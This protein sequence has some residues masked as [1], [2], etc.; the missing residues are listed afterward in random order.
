MISRMSVRTH[1]QTETLTKQDSM[2]M[3]KN[4]IKLGISLV[5]YLRNLF[6][7]NAYEEVHIQELKL[8]KLLPINREAHMIINWLEK[9]VFDAIEKEYLRILILDINDIYDNSIECYKFSF[10]YNSF[11]GGKIGITLETS[12]NNPSNVSTDNI[13]EEKRKNFNIDRLKDIKDRL[14]N[15]NKKKKETSLCFKKD[16]KQKTYELLRSLVLLTQTLNPLP[17]R[18]YLSMKLLYYDEIVPYNYQ[19][20]Y[21]RNPDSKDL[22]KFVNIPNEEH[23]GKV[24]TGHHYLS[25]IVNST[26]NNHDEQASSYN[27]TDVHNQ[28]TSNS[29]THY[30]K[31]V[32]GDYYQYDNSES[33]YHSK[34]KN[35]HGQN[36]NKDFYLHTDRNNE[37]PYGYHGVNHNGDHNKYVEYDEENCYKP[38]HFDESRYTYLNKRLSKKRHRKQNKNQY[39]IIDDEEYDDQEEVKMSNC[40]ISEGVYGRSGNNR[41]VDN[42]NAAQENH[43]ED[44]S[45]DY[46]YYDEYDDES[47]NDYNNEEEYSSFSNEQVQKGTKR[48]LKLIGRKKRKT[49]LAP[50]FSAN[51]SYDNMSPSRA[52][53]VECSNDQDYSSNSENNEYY[54]K[55]GKM[56]VHTHRYDD[57]KHDCVQVEKREIEQIKRKKNKYWAANKKVYDN[58]YYSSNPY[59]SN[60]EKIAT[61]LYGTSYGKKLPY[62][63]SR[64]EVTNE[65]N[66]TYD[67]RKKS[68]E[69]TNRLNKSHKLDL[70]NPFLDKDIEKKWIKNKYENKKNCAKTHKNKFLMKIKNKKKEKLVCKNLKNKKTFQKT[71]MLKY[72]KKNM[73]HSIRIYITRYKIL[74]KTKI[75]QKFPNVTNCD[76][77]T[78]LHKL[79]KDNIIRKNGC[80]SYTFV[81]DKGCKKKNLQK[82]Y[83]PQVDYYQTQQQVELQNQGEKC[84]GKTVESRDDDYTDFQNGRH[85]DVR[86]ESGESNSHLDKKSNSDLDQ[87]GKSDICKERKSDI[88]KERKSDIGKERK[89]DRANEPAKDAR[90]DPPTTHHPAEHVENEDVNFTNVSK[91]ESVQNCGIENSFENIN[92]S[93]HQSSHQNILINNISESFESQGR[94]S[95]HMEGENENNINEINNDIQKLYNDVHNLC[96]KTKYINKEIVTKGLG[97][98]PLLAKP[99]IDRLMREGVIKKKIIKNKGYE[100]N[101]FVPMENNFTMNNRIDDTNQPDILH[102]CDALEGDFSHTND[103]QNYVEN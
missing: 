90:R 27:C 78:V 86:R 75:K 9:G 103:L 37:H 73:L 89:I 101:I 30:A 28:D 97:I 40:H 61:R 41:I 69:N 6:E 50:S 5:T 102:S 92:Q 56:L 54:N 99:L 49:F 4:I 91:E 10:S 88:C 57:D 72:K 80:E 63:R 14:L 38:F 18:T 42:H 62:D 74:S 77:D 84:T 55:V 34:E 68:M 67:I 59:R 24:D 48:N 20:P 66:K 7:E 98:Y 95:Y 71:F 31:V 43:V 36:N 60:I 46:D 3:L 11:M 70:P 96:L 65:L 35:Q 21:F 17:E 15:K 29:S 93:S 83:D 52:R 79:M 47:V 8:K 81:D 85:K 100:S 76:I 32:N 39:I 12:K 19:P 44:R 87:K 51:Q 23:V 58:S 45:D 33:E 82:R 16:A 2:N 13:V 64:D 94:H 26:C 25:I 22:L 1:T 53:S